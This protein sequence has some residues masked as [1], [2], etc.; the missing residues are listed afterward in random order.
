MMLTVEEGSARKTFAER[1]LK[2]YENK[3]LKSVDEWQW[4]PVNP[5]TTPNLSPTYD[6]FTA[7]TVPTGNPQYAD[8][9]PDSDP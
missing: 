2:D 8:S 4:T 7:T 5:V 6:T 1:F 3:E 9:Q